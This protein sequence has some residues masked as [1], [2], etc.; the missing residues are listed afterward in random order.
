MPHLHQLLNEGDIEQLQSKL[1]FAEILS[2]SS[3]S[4]FIPGLTIARKEHTKVRPRPERNPPRAHLRICRCACR[5]PGHAF[6]VLVLQ[7]YAPLVS[8]NYIDVASTLRFFLFPEKYR[9]RILQN[10]EMECSKAV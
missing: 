7:Q 9:R 3:G 6:S 10:C 1:A 2:T 8:A 4:D 5:G